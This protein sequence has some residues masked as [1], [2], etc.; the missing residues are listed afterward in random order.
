MQISNLFVHA[1]FILLLNYNVGKTSNSAQ[2]FHFIF[3]VFQSFYVGLK[4]A[5]GEKICI[6]CI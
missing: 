4:S 1:L 6:M 3:C 5:T 2:G